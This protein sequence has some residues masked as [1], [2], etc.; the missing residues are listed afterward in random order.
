[1]FIETHF[2][3]AAARWQD[4]AAVEWYGY[5]PAYFEDA[6]A[7]WQDAEAQWYVATEKQLVIE[8]GETPFAIRYL[9]VLTG[10]PDVTIPISSAQIRRRDGEPTYLAVTVPGSSWLSA[11]T[12]RQD[13]DM[14]ISKKVSYSDGNTEEREITRVDLE[15]I[16]IDEGSSSFT[17]SLTGHR[18]VTN[19]GP[20]TV[21]LTGVSYINTT[22]G[23][24]R[25]RCTINPWLAPGDTARFGSVNFTVGYISYTI[26]TRGG[27]MEV[28]E[29]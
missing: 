8:A 23:K 3:D 7:Q 18:T 13:G 25:Y 28:V 21:E 22:G 12:T 6:A 2:K 9:F 15:D 27:Q 14:V 29:A 16:R 26:S 5:E 4:T 10:S 17:V 24:R 11:I 20:K 1:M 19:T